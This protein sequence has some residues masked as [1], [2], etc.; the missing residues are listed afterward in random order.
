MKHTFIG[1]EIENYA[2][3]VKIVPLT[4]KNE[5]AVETD[6]VLVCGVM[7]LHR[8]FHKLTLRVIRS[9]EDDNHFVTRFRLEIDTPCYPDQDICRLVH[10]SAGIQFY[11]EWQKDGRFWSRKQ[12]IYKAAKCACCSSS[13]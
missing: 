13:S 5:T 3:A 7:R 8:L 11:D 10:V 4:G 2:F 12:V 6:A 9:G 1:C